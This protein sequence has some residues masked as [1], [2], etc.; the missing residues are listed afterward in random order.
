MNKHFFFFF[1]FFAGIGFESFSQNLNDT[2]NDSSNILIIHTCPF[3]LYRDS[4]PKIKLP[5]SLGGNMAKGRIGVSAYLNND[6]TIKSYEIFYI[7]LMNRKTG[8]EIAYY[9]D[10]SMDSIN[11]K[12]I[13]SNNYSRVLRR[14]SNF[15][16][17]EMKRIHFQKEKDADTTIH[18]HYMVAFFIK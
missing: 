14:Y 7:N 1:I 15:I 10:H 18:C 8:R 5:D 9:S 17:N 16:S 13:R 6:G 11:I 3:F 12:Q 4:V 2:V